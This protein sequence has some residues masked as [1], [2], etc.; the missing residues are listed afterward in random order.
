MKNILKNSVG[1]AILSAG[2]ILTPV[3]QAAQDTAQ[4]VEKTVQDTQK[5]STQPE[6]DIVQEWTDAMKQL[7]KPEKD[8]QPNTQIPRPLYDASLVD[9]LTKL[10]DSIDGEDYDVTY[11]IYERI[12]MVDETKMTTE[13][14]KG[15]QEAF[16]KIVRSG[17]AA[18][19][20][21]DVGVLVLMLKTITEPWNGI[22][23]GERFVVTD[24][25]EAFL[26]EKFDIPSGKM[27]LVYQ[28]RRLY[29]LSENNLNDPK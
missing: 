29:V 13:V 4:Q 5:S 27:L 20:E 19:S 22:D 21:K 3:S 23:L 1:G 7:Q 26:R 24:L 28:A 11:E 18:N 10:G 12:R 15:L 9:L 16:R 6:R 14:C 8:R 17:Y 2:I 25:S